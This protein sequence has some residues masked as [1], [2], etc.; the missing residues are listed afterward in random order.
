MTPQA[1]IQVLPENQALPRDRMLLLFT[2]SSM[3]EALQQAAEAHIEDVNAWS[4]RACVCG[5]WT[6]GYEVRL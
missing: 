2:G 4:C 1:H 3:R 6:V 5:E